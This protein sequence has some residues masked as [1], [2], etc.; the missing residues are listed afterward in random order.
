MDRSVVDANIATVRRICEGWHVLSL[1]EF[2][3]LC[4]PQMDYRNIPIEG[5][6]HIGP[7]AAHAVLSSFGRKWDIRLQ[8]DRIVGDENVVM[9]ERHEFFD[10]KPGVKP[11]FVLPV[12]GIFEL[13]DGKVTA[14]R[15]YFELSHLRVR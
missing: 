12:M 2:Q 7:E 3:Q 1:E 13:R 10:H 6:R 15:D 8:I 4:D 14:W 9:T 11:S 5:D